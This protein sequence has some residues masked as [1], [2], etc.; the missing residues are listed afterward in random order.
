MP[1]V[2]P[3]TRT[4]CP[5]C[6]ELALEQKIRAETVQPLPEAPFAPVGVDGRKCCFDCQSADNIV[7]LGIVPGPW[8]KQSFLMARIAVGNDRQEQYR[9]PGIPIG[10]VMA[11][12]VRPSKRGD[13]EKQ[14]KWLD[15][16]KWFGQMLDEET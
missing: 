1:R 9:L 11:G 10:L 12:H 5:R 14:L 3:M 6:A 13:F 15:E 8:D 16:N 4:P 7:K 2:V